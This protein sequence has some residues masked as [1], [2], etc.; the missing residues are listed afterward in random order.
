VLESA[1]E[2]KENI[3]SKIAK[4]LNEEIQKFAKEFTS[5]ISVGVDSNGPPESSFQVQLSVKEQNPDTLKSASI[6][7]GKQISKICFDGSKA[8]VTDNCEEKNRIVAQIDDGYTTKTGSIIDIELNRAKLKEKGLSVGGLDSILVNQT[9]KSQFETGDGEA[10]TTVQS[11]GEDID[12]VLDKQQEDTKTKDALSGSTLTNLLGQNVPLSDVAT[13]NQKDAKSAISRV[14]GQAI[15]VVSAKLKEGFTD[16]NVSAAVTEAI[17]DFYSKDNGD[18]AKKLNLK[19]SSIESFSEGGSAGFLKSF[20]ELGIA[21]VIAIILT[22]IVLAIFFNSLLQPIVIL[23]TIPVT[24]IGIMPG[25]S[26]FAGGQFGFLEIIGMIILIGIVENAAIFLVDSARQRIHDGEQP[27]KAI[28]V[29]SGLR[30][31]P[32]LLTNF[33][34][35]ASLAPLAFL[36]EL[37]R[38]I[39]I[40]IMFGLFASGFISLITTPILFIFFRWVSEQFT[41]LKWYNKLLFF[42]FF[43]IYI[44]A[45]GIKDKNDETN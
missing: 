23:Y 29:S 37:Y 25:L 16:Q 27:K 42:P 38:S 17:V 2:R 13:L 22:Y 30:F 24:L 9:I 40:V 19:K 12:V 14:K 43:P 41:S 6:E 32:V 21:L 28:A 20:N 15:N 33:T 11:G 3:S 7:I 34:A 8:T 44:I 26:W 4:S 36:S 35:I 10:L 45:L 5:E 39:S 31:R 1:Q 18:E